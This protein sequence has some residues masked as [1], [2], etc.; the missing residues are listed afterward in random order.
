MADPVV[1]KATVRLLQGKCGCRR[2]DGLTVV[3][4]PPKKY[5]RKFSKVRKTVKHA[6]T[7]FN[8]A[9]LTGLHT[10]WCVMGFDEEV[11][12]ETTMPLGEGLAYE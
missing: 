12:Y 7:R 10:A 1:W 8:P 11:M 4:E 3:V 5:V 9:K 2:C 6:N